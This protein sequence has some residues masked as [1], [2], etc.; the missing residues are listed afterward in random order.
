MTKQPKP[1]FVCRKCK[2][3][4]TAENAVMQHGMPLGSICRTCFW[5]HVPEPRTP[6]ERAFND[7]WCAPGAEEARLREIAEIRAELARQYEEDL[8]KELG[9]DV[10]DCPDL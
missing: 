6:W 2:A 8:R 5:A 4:I 7:A 3:K 1:P 9:A 10:V